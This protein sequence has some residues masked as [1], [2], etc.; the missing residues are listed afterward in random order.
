MV[1]L[2][3]HGY[4]LRS[5]AKALMRN[6]KTVRQALKEEGLAEPTAAKATEP[7]PLKKLDSFLEVIADKV[8]KRLTTSRI[9]R[10]IRELGYTGGRTILAG[11][12][13]SLRAPLAPR[14][15]A[16]RRFETRAGL[17][18]QVDWATYTVPIAGQPTKVYALVV[19]LAHS[20]KVHAHFYRDQRESTLLEGLAVV[21]EAFGGVTIRVVFDNMSTVVLGRIGP[22]GK[23][24]WHPRFRDFLGYY[25]FSAF[26]CKVKDPDRKGKDER[27]IG[28][29]E[30][31]FVRGSEFS[32]FEDLNQRAQVWASTANQRKHGT[33]GL[34]PDEVWVSERDFLIQLPEVRFAT[35][36]DQIHQVGPDA[37]LS[38]GGTLYTVPEHLHSRSVAVRL[39][40]EHFEVLNPKG[41]VA[42]S[43]RYV[44]PADKGKLQIDPSHYQP[45]PGRAPSAF[46]SRSDEL[47]VKRFPR[48]AGLVAGIQTRMKSLA[49]VHLNALLRLASRYGDEAFESA[50]LRAQ[51]YR[52]FSADGVRRILEREH[53]LV[54][55]APAVV[56]VGESARA[57]SLVSEVEAASFESFAHL[58][59]ADSQ[60]PAPSATAVAHTADDR[61]IPVTD[62]ATDPVQP[63][64]PEDPD[65]QA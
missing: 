33:T 38:V 16:K 56:P 64:T 62:A 48:L 1:E 10:E 54:D 22:N 53:P 50:A 35:H 44:E 9:L 41:G 21:F 36:D 31:D 57:V 30:Q 4:G 61:E 63:L 5:I 28:F 3:R 17:E 45:F 26:L 65:E 8:S 34:V 29:C 58:D 60:A 27:V 46:G 43:R 18:S 59:S 24:V 12:V 40:A 15:R 2:R 13:R 51:D 11:L 20:R 6:R 49:P 47:L 19:T 32:S 23:P 7:A 37:T 55:S 52:R 39:Y 14:R 42:F 25:G